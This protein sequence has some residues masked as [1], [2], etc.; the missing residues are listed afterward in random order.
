MNANH[1]RLWRALLRNP[2]IWFGFTILSVVFL[3]AIFAP[4][5]TQYTA[6]DMDISLRLTGPSP[7]HWLGCDVNG[8]DVWTALLYGARLS[9]FISFFT[10]FISVTVGTAVGLISG[11]RLG[12]IDTIFM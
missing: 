12:I 10:V 5:L 4:L 1:K 2:R 3:A 6:D 11:F 7:E 8:S 9:L